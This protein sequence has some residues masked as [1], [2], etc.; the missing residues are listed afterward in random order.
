MNS[1][2]GRKWILLLVGL[3]P[4]VGIVAQNDSLPTH[5]RLRDF[6]FV[7]ATNPWL[8][9]DNAAG[10]TQYDS[11]NIATAEVNY[12]FD[13]GGLVNYDGSPRTI[14]L[15]AETEAYQ[16]LSKRIALYGKISY[17]SFSGHD[18]AGSAF[19]ETERLPFNLV[20][21]S[22][23]N[24]G[25]KYKDTYNLV[26][27][28]GVNVWKG[29]SLGVKFDYTAANYA[30]YKDLRHKTKLMNMVF[31]AGA[32]YQAGVFTLGAD[33]FYR[34]NTQTITFS[35]Y[36]KSEK[37]YYTLVDYGIFTGR[38]EYFGSEGFTDKS[39]EMPLLN[40][41]QGVG[42][43]LG[44]AITPQ[45][46]FYNAFRAAHRDGYYGRKSPYTITFT[47]HKSNTYHYDANLCLRL[48]TSQHVL[49]FSLDAEDLEN[50]M[51]TR[52]NL[53]NDL[54]ATYYEYFTPVKSANKQWVNTNIDYTTYFGTHLNTSVSAG[55]NLMHRKQT[56]YYYPYYR[57]QNIHSREYYLQGQYNWFIRKGYFT[58][59][60]RGS[61][62]QGSGEP[63][64]EGIY[65]AAPEMSKTVTPPTMTAYL[66][67][68]Y[69]YLTANQYSAKGSVAYTFPFIKRQPDLL[70]YIKGD[71]EHRKA[72]GLPKN[73]TD[74]D[75][76]QIVNNYLTGCDRLQFCLSVGC[77]F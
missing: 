11:R 20:E 46:Y 27:G 71:I 49:R 7:K 26:G 14:S 65:D 63:Y 76:N 64:E 62:A 75:G 15:G 8:T 42:V 74:S 54:G 29:L 19:I 16:R 31:T 32:T 67:R 37:D 36:G 25:K 53:T 4:T 18:M 9:S 30:K 47:N 55:V 23:T 59:S 33:Y 2:V 72:N 61:Y 1:A 28:I 38:P 69:Q 24:L 58:F 66:Y 44:I 43:Q 77:H 52:Q 35:T 39:R 22:L 70:L 21:D 73:T 13:K 56:V 34:R 3:L 41:Y 6:S 48:K 40:D 10:L 50:Y 51:T 12:E 60:L 45:L 5:F 68:E 57:R 17:N